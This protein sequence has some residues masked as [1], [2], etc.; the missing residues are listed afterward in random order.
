MN[1]SSDLPQGWILETVKTT[2]KLLSIL[3]IILT[4]VGFIYYFAQK[5]M[6]YRDQF[7]LYKFKSQ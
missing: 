3:I 7:K 4:I 5:K 6:E 1:K 2:Q